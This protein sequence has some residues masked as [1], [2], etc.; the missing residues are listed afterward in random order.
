[1]NYVPAVTK[2]REELLSE[3]YRSVARMNAH[4]LADN[5]DGVIAEQQLQINLRSNFKEL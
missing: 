4:I 5:S 1:M 3:L 2:A